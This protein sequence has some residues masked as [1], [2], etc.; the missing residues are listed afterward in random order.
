MIQIAKIL[1]QDF[2]EVRVD[3]YEISQKPIFGELTFTTG[4]GYWRK[5]FYR[6]IGSL[7]DISKVSKQII[8]NKPKKYSI[9]N[10][11]IP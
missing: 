9:F 7:L 3:L 6:E 5:E 4:Y 2:P 10:L 8:M 11:L 1:S